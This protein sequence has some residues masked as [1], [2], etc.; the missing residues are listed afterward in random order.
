MGELIPQ[1]PPIGSPLINIERNQ[2]RSDVVELLEAALG[3]LGYFLPLEFDPSDISTRTG[4][5]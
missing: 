4:L 2:S 3:D 5:L 1:K